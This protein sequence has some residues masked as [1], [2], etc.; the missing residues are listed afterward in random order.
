MRRLLWRT[1]LL[2]V[3]LTLIFN[4]ERLDFEQGAVVN[5]PSFFYGLAAATVLLLLWLP[6]SRR[7]LPFVVGSILVAH[8]ASRAVLG[9]PLFDGVQKYLLFTELTALLVTAGLTWWLGRVVHDFEDAVAAISLPK[10]HAR[11]LSPKKLDKRLQAEMGRARRHRQPLSVALLTIDP[12]TFQAALHQAARDVQAAMLARYVRVRV[13]LFLGRRIRESDVIAQHTKSGDFLLVAPQTPADQAERML[14][15]L[16][17][18]VENE[19]QIR[20]Q[21]RVADF[22]TTAL[23][24]EELVRHVKDDQHP[25][26]SPMRDGATPEHRPVPATEDGHEYR[27]DERRSVAEG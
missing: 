23:T 25:V 11:V 7:Q 16:A 18:A 26:V 13:A 8:V 24:A 4:I 6:P 9:L 12:T 22:P 2:I 14:E 3:W 1:T 27:V 5:L 20:I 10:G 21:Y 17:R 15:R 19:M